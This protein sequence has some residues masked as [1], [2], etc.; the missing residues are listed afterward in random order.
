[1][2]RKDQA[3]ETTAWAPS[4]LRLALV[5][6]GAFLLL[7]GPLFDPALQLAGRDTSR[8]YYPVKLAIAQSLAQGRLL[9]WDTW[10]ESGVSILGQLTPG[11]LHPFTLLYVALPFDLAFKLNHLLALPL[12]G[13]GAFLLAREL[14]ASR[15]A[16]L[17]AAFAYGGS[18]ALLSAA[19]S[20]LPFALGAATLPGALAALLWLLR[21]PS[22]L[23]LLGAAAVLSLCAY[24]GDPQSMLLAALA[25]LVLTWQ[26]KRLQRAPW[27]LAWAAAAL[28]LSLPV[29]LPAV[30]QLARSPR[31]AGAV[32]LAERGA[33]STTPLRLLGLAIPIALDGQEDERGQDTSSEFL[34]Q[35]ASPFYDSLCLGLPALLFACS[36]LGTGLGRTLWAL[37]AI[38]LLAACGE[39]LFV[40]GLLVRVLPL[41]RY[42]R[43]TEK[44]V[45]PACCFLAVA[46]ALGADCALGE[47]GRPRKLVI[48]SALLA[49][50]FALA[51][52]PLRFAQA[53]LVRSLCS[54]GHSHDPSLAQRFAGSLAEGALASAG[55]A[56]LVALVAALW[57][58]R[59]RL[60]LSGA[61]MACVAA[62]LLTSPRSLHAIPA[63]AYRGS[64]VTSAALLARAGPSEGR[65]RI[66]SSPGQ[67]LFTPAGLDPRE[68][69]TLAAREALWPQ[70]TQLDRIETAASYFSAP[71][72]SYQEAMSRAQPALLQL[73]GARFQVLSPEEKIDSGASAERSE[74][75]FPY[76]AFSPQPRAFLLESWHPVADAEAAL[77][78][79]A[80]PSFDPHATAAI[81]GG[82][83]R[84][85]GPLSGAPVQLSRPHPEQIEAQV[86]T[87]QRALLVVAEHHD[88]GW[89]ALVDGAP[90][91]L[92]A[93]DGLALGVLVP[94]GQH[95]VS[96][97]YRP[98]GFLP[99]CLAA[100]LCAAALLFWPRGK[101]TRPA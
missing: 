78:E 26:Q 49:A 4:P 84:Q 10:S 87:W 57:A 72:R 69:R 20:N 73:F 48:G 100:L 74:T 86:E 63:L 56:G 42:F 44:L 31:G 33:F 43:Y 39:A 79:F 99:G 7:T 58:Q 76:L 36:A 98:R 47:R 12:A 95:R 3:T 2:P 27:L 81:P 9:F 38:L 68:A 90:A 28:L 80:L 96:F 77:R 70:L 88:P 25:G 55:L 16:A 32:S 37:A 91:E 65:W 59:P 22:P 83:S 66:F 34:G 15:V 75:G 19:S 60:A 89:S 17:C 30:V 101:R 94:P 50:V 53:P 41:W 35:G 14:S 93:V 40:Q 29:A 23:R 67:R 97:A 51:L 1:M 11:L 46:A 85:S 13:L 92:L 64:S 8:L 62:A 5:S 18:G 52:L 45:T 82:S 61:A 71:D 21:A 54:L 24:A 6:A